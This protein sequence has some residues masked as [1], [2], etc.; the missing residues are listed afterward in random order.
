MRE[1]RGQHGLEGIK[2][3]IYLFLYLHLGKDFALWRKFYGYMNK[4]LC[5]AAAIMDS[6]HF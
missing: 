4:G 5:V 1:A 2:F 6:L 3:L